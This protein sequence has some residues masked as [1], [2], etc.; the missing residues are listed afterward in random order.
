MKKLFPFFIL[1]LLLLLGTVFADETNGGENTQLVEKIQE[2]L[3]FDSEGLSDAG[4]IELQKQKIISELETI[5]QE[6]ND[7]PSTIPSLAISLFG[8]DTINVYLD[9]GYSFFV[10]FEEGKAVAAGEGIVDNADIE[11]RI[12]DTVF[13]AL[14]EGSFQTKEALQNG[15]IEYKGLTFLKKIQLG[16]ISSIYNIASAGQ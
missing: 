6:Y 14:N 15:D 5:E 1:V 3:A 7:N 4:I 16:I 13:Q 12:R 11:V 2:T 8:D 9:G 10:V